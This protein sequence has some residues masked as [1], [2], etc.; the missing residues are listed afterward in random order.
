M[1]DDG[2]LDGVTDGFDHQWTRRARCQQDSFPMYEPTK[3]QDR[4]M[5]LE[6][7]VYHT[8]RGA[9]LPTI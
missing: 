6:P 5:E 4:T 2:R 9:N 1:Q 3:L 7:I 8:P